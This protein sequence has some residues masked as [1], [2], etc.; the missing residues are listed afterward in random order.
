MLGIRQ[1]QPF[2]NH[3]HVSNKNLPPKAKGKKGLVDII[4]AGTRQVWNRKVPGTQ[5]EKLKGIIQDKYGVKFEN[6][7]DFHEWSIKNY[8]QF[9]QEVWNFY[10]VVCSKPFSQPARR[11][12]K[13]IIDIEW[14]PGARLNYAE[15][16][17]RYRDD[18]VA[19]IC[20]DEDG[21]EEKVT[22]AQMFEEVKLFAAAFKKIGLR[23][24][25]RL[26]CYMSN[27][28]E[29]IFAMLAAASMGAMFG[30]P[31]PFYGAKA[32]AA[33]MDIMQPKF[34]ITVDRFQFNKDELDL[35][36]RLPEIVNANKSIEKVIIIPSR[37]DSK[38][39]DISVVRNSIFLDEFLEGGYQPDGSVPDL[40][41]EQF[42]F[43][44]PVFIN[45]TSGTTGLP[46][47]LVHS[48]GTFLALL[49][50]FGLHCN[51]DRDSVTLAMQPVGWN[52]WNL[53]VG[54]LMLGTS[55]LLYDGLPAFLSKHAF[56]DILDK[57]KVTFAFIVTS[58]IDTFEKEDIVPAPGCNLDHLKMIAIGA[59]P[60]K[61]QN[62]DFIL[63]KVNPNIFVGCLYGA[64]EV[65][66]V[67]SGFDYNSPVY[68]SEIQCPALGVDL[69]T[70][71]DEGNSIVGTPGELVLA[72][73]TP[74]LPICVW[75]D[76]H[77][78]KMH[79]TY[80]SKFPAKGVWAQSDEAWIDP[81]T[82]GIIIIG[83]S[84]NTIKQHGERFVSE[85][86]Y[87]AIHDIEEIADSICVA[88]S[89]GAG[90][91]RA[92]L[93]VKMKNG[94]VFDQEMLTKIEETILRELTIFYIPKVILPVKDIPYNLN[95]KR[96]E[97]VVKKIINTNTL[98]EVNNIRNPDCLREYYNIPQLQNF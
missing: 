5:M 57:Y 10:G 75:N 94:H 92:V 2:T 66:G 24:G 17:L 83:R 34:L 41:F 40:I 39:K 64:T 55:L 37:A 89:N 21:N 9:W 26:A 19:L 67:F 12:G 65:I 81:K 61:L 43:D 69:R 28:K 85:E 45:F 22:F 98:P 58:I 77:G 32:V 30:G 78:T 20:V 53:Y 90:D 15:N 86:I 72:T 8:P 4:S 46:K 93:F 76:E 16:I 3:N 63:H 13:E 54:N 87:W 27:R 51:L 70:F 96:M 71:D 1:V 50:D 38:L 97:S 23:K 7:W 14:F 68:S 60:V 29:A 47:G 84:D 35:L 42:P 18:R 80:L 62:V 48:A 6:Y 91:G 52:L 11:K 25:D 88:Q 79:E 33:I 44:Y 95:G 73:P 56:W 82:K 31:L 36:E 49:R 59:S 74:S